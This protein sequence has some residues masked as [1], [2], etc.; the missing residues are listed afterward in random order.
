MAKVTFTVKDGDVL[1]MFDENIKKLTP[2]LLEDTYKFFVKT[3]PVRSGNARRNTELDRINNTISADYPYAGRLNN[4]WSKQAPDG[5][6]EPA[7]EYMKRSVS[8][9]LKGKGKV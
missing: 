7:I 4:G 6:T 5:M 1:D 3:T 9:H 2:R 8:K